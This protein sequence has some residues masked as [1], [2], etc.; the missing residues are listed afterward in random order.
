MPSCLPLF[1]VDYGA[2]RGARNWK[3]QA[4]YTSNRR[5]EL[6]PAQRV[7]EHEGGAKPRFRRMEALAPHLGNGRPT[8]AYGS[9]QTPAS[10]QVSTSP[11]GRDA[12]GS[13]P[14]LQLEGQ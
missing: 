5:A 4:F 1:P 9:I 14:Y 8:K 13:Y 6:R 12:R 2:F 11:I 10:V 3:S 7:D